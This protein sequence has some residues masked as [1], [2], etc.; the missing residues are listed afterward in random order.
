[1]ILNTH[2]PIKAWLDPQTA[3]LPGVGRV[4]IEDWLTQ[5]DTFAAQ[6]AYRRELMATKREAVFQS[7][8]EAEAA[9]AKLRNIICTEENFP[10]S[11]QNTRS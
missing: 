7:K 4:T 1:M 2:L 11:K 6:M 3:R 10:T 9:C 5:S 8:P